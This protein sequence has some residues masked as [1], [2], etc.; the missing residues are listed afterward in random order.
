MDPRETTVETFSKPQIEHGADDIIGATGG[1]QENTCEVSPTSIRAK[2]SKDKKS[3]STLIQV[4][5]K[6][7]GRSAL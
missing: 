5:A 2:G 1:F 6:R 7:L 4:N 3:N